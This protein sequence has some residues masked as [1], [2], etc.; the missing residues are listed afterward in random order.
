MYFAA[1]AG[2]DHEALQ[3]RVAIGSKI[4]ILYQC[5]MRIQ[6][7]DWRADQKTVRQN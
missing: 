7:S 6:P 1:K 5:I 3:G 4:S 2:Q